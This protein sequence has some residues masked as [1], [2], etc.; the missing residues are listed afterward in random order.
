MTFEV[1]AAPAPAGEVPAAWRGA[2]QPH[3][4]PQENVRACLE[5]DLDE[6]LHFVPSVVL[7]TNARLISLGQGG[8]SQ[9]W[10]YR[11]DLTLGHH[12]H[13]GVGHLELSDAHGLLHRWRF[14]L[15]QNLQALRLVDQFMAQ[16]NSAVSGLPVAPPCDRL[17]KRR[18]VASSSVGTKCRRSSR[19]SSSQAKTFSLG[20]MCGKLD[21]SQGAGIS[22][23]AGAARA[24]SWVMEM[25]RF[26][27]TSN[28]LQRSTGGAWYAHF[29]PHY[30]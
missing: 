13:A 1:S 9:D 6:R 28:R 11:A 19:S 15:G 4:H 29:S 23:A 3:L 17:S 20:A 7:A 26:L 2:I 24:R 21:A 18:L 27:F 30:A 22:P 25:N 14:T 12:D 5:V 8:A 10:P 16:Q